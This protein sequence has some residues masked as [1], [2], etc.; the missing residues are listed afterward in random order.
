M[1]LNSYP[2]AVL[3]SDLIAG[4]HMSHVLCPAND[5]HKRARRDHCWEPSVVCSQVVRGYSRAGQEGNAGR[6]KIGWERAAQGRFRPRR[7]TGRKQRLPPNPNPAP[8][9]E[10]IPGCKGDSIVEQIAKGGDGFF[11]D[12]DLPAGT[13]QALAGEE[14]FL[15]Q[16]GIGLDNLAGSFYDSAILLFYPSPGFG[17]QHGSAPV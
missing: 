12:G 7:G 9:P 1:P 11:L 5:H 8:N 17:A 14:D 10:E 4:Q 3:G 13:Q 2:A 15:L 6:G 16:E